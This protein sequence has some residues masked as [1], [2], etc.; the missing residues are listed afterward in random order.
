MA[1]WGTSVRTS[2][3][4]PG[5]RKVSRSHSSRGESRAGAQA[6][7]FAVVVTT[8]RWTREATPSYSSSVCS[9]HSEAGEV[10]LEITSG[11]AADPSTG[12]FTAASAQLIQLGQGEIGFLEKENDNRNRGDVHGNPVVGILLGPI[13]LHGH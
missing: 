3:T 4:F 6:N 7:T 8:G 2:Y 13:R 10:Q 11:I 12:K 5:S 9:V 1:V